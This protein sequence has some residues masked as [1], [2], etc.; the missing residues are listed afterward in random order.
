MLNRIIRKVFPKHNKALL[1]KKVLELKELKK[2]SDEIVICGS[3]T[4]GS[5]L[6]IA[7]ATHSLFPDK[8]YTLP[9]WYSHPVFNEKEM[10]VWKEALVSLQFTKI[11]IS[12]FATFFFD[13]ISEYGDKQYIEVIYH[14]T[15]SEMHDKSQRDWMARLFQ[16]TG[17][18]KIKKIGFI[19]EGMAETVNKLFGFDCEHIPLPRPEIPQGILKLNLDRSKFHIGV[20]GADTFNKNLHNQVVHALLIENAIIHVLDKS[21][22]EYLNIT[23]RIIE[24]GKN[25]PKEK[26]LQILGSMD[27][28]LYM[29][30]SESW[31]L[32]NYESEAM[33]VPCIGSLNVNY[34]NLIKL[35]E[36]K[37]KVN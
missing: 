31:G 13:L 6:G 17:I 18:G 29:S 22:F 11:V 30:Y 35:E 4:E 9:Q 36:Q 16:L 14:G 8:T 1:D 21:I 24:H 25:V 19:K 32:V 33:G 2:R 12:G 23:E 3:P 26:F 7:N 37:R 28:N 5:W 27:L 20:F 10:K 34:L 15:W